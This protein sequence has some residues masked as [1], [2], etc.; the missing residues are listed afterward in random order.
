MVIVG[1][2]CVVWMCVSVPTGLVVGRVINEM[3][4]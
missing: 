1:F 4:K 3:G 2:V